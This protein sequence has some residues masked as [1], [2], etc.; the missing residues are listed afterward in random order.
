M[1]MRVDF[2]GLK[3][4]RTTKTLTGCTHI[5]NSL[6]VLNGMNSTDKNTPRRQ[7][8]GRLQPESCGSSTRFSQAPLAA[9]S[10]MNLQGHTNWHHQHTK[11]APWAAPQWAYRSSQRESIHSR[12]QADWQSTGNRRVRK[13]TGAC[14]AMIRTQTSCQSHAPTGTP[15]KV[16]TP[17]SKRR[18]YA[19]ACRFDSDNAPSAAA[20][21]AL[22]T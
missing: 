7:I 12:L 5:A 21:S 9:E 15:H 16:Q 11:N 20:H 4:H 14:L 6:F 17:P 2:F 18:R 22:P 13:N 8:P 1:N 10:A 3:T 19:P